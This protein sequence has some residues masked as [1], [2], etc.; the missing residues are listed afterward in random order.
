MFLCLIENEATAAVLILSILINQSY[1]KLN[2]LKPGICFEDVQV[3]LH[4]PFSCA[5]QNEAIADVAIAAILI[6][7][8]VFYY[9]HTVLSAIVSDLWLFLVTTSVERCLSACTVFFII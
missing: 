5:I 1:F 8:L 2:V 7:S 9:W 6:L 4:C 3:Y